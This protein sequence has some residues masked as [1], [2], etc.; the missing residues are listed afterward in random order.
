MRVQ[1]TDANTGQYPHPERLIGGWGADAIHP[2]VRID[3]VQHNISTLIGLHA[4]VI[5]EPPRRPD[6]TGGRE[7]SR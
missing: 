3:Y 5:G 1:F 4:L 6:A 2:V 7:S